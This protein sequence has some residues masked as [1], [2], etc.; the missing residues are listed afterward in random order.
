MTNKVLAVWADP[1]GNRTALFTEPKPTLTKLRREIS[2]KMLINVFYMIYK[3]KNN[4]YH[5][6]VILGTHYVL[7]YTHKY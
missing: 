4:Q 1:M 7:I 3:W 5:L 2:L 6:C